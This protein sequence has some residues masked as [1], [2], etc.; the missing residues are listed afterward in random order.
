[1]GYKMPLF[2]SNS[3]RLSKVNEHLQKLYGR[4]LSSTI[5]KIPKKPVMGKKYCEITQL[6]RSQFF[7]FISL[8]HCTKL[9]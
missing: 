9:H 3:H 4:E 8:N 6:F 1:M 5:C 2:Y 7:N